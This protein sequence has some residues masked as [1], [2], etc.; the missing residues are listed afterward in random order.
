VLWMSRGVVMY[1]Q[2]GMGLLVSDVS[3]RGTDLAGCTRAGLG[4]AMRRPP[5]IAGFVSLLR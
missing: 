2:A 4:A 5:C 3:G 1:S